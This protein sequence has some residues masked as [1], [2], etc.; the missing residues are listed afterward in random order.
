MTDPRR[1]TDANAGFTVIE[2]LIAMTILALSAVTL[3][4]VSEAQVG[5]IDGLETR[6]IA[7]WV[8]ENALADLAVSNGPIPEEPQTASMLGRDWE[9]RYVFS[10]T[11]DPDLAAVTL[12]VVEAGTAGPASVLTGFLDV[13]GREP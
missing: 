9:V 2:A 4:G 8:G 11:E 1:P 5:R 13:A 3:I 12:S 10:Q 6:A 7:L